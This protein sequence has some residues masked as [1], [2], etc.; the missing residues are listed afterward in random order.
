MDGPSADGFR[1]SDGGEL[2]P[3]AEY[4]LVNIKQLSEEGKYQSAVKKMAKGISNDKSF[5]EV[6]DIRVTGAVVSGT[7]K[8][9]QR[10][11]EL[12]IVRAS[13]IGATTDLY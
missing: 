10:F 9:L 7:P 12:G 1:V 11:Q 5:P 8:E 4:F 2:I 13:T 6:N 3:F